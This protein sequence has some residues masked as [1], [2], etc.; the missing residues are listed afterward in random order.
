M[1]SFPGSGTCAKS[2]LSVCANALMLI[3][4]YPGLLLLRMLLYASMPASLVA[5]VS[6]V[7]CMFCVGAL[8]TCCGNNWKMEEIKSSILKAFVISSYVLSTSDSVARI[9]VGNW[10]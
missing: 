8:G 3:P 9:L 6:E 1:R 10:L 5:S 7:S 2:V 4:A